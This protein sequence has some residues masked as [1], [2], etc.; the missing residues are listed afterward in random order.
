MS[1]P[2]RPPIEIFEA[3][4]CPWCEREE[5]VLLDTD[6]GHVNGFHDAGRRLE[7]W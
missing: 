4:W 1:E 3:G 6:M 5:V 2:P 7:L